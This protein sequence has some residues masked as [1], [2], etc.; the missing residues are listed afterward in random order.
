MRRNSYVLSLLGAVAL[1]GVALAGC[2]DDGPDNGDLVV[3]EIEVSDQT[4][5]PADQVVIDRVVSDGPGW[6]VIHADDGSGA[7]GE[8]LG[9][10]GAPQGEST[11]IIVELDR[12]LADG[13]TL[14]AMFHVDMGEVGVYE[15]PGADAPATD[16]A[17]DVVV[18][19]FVVVVATGDATVEVVDQTLE[20]LSTIVFVDHVFSFGPGWVV[21]H[22]DDGSGGPGVVV[23]VAGVGDG[24]TSDLS[25]ELERPVT[26]GETLHAMLHEDAGAVGEY[27]FPGDD[28][29][30]T[31]DAGDVVN[32]PFEVTVPLETPAVRL[33]LTNV[34]LTAWEVS[35]VEPESWTESII[36]DGGEN[37]TLA[38]YPEWRYEVVNSV[39]TAH[40][41]E[42]VTRGED[43][44]DDIVLLSQA[45]DGSLEDDMDVL[46]LDDGEGAVSF[47]LTD[48][49][50]SSVDGYRCSIHSVAMR[51]AVSLHDE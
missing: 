32:T 19:D 29:P 1:V 26:D 47:T 20:D 36:G 15:F 2:D 24:E 35:T 34:G 45:S 50:A 11:D 42:L 6:A 38:L 5:D 39:P 21:I 22:E 46:W 37:P 48:P 41:F 31:D 8:V 28:V 9:V 18:D 10:G 44:V 4:V 51:G 40:P 7:P 49:L 33:G 12:P 3:P 17:G 43:P 27:E 25:V 16:D 23:G 14:F 13:E 30:V